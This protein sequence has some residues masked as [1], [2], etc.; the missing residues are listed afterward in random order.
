[1]Q[2]LP[3]LL[4]GVVSNWAVVFPRSLVRWEVLRHKQKTNQ[5]FAGGSTVFETNEVPYVRL[6]EELYTLLQ[7]VTP[8]EIVWYVGKQ[9][10]DLEPDIV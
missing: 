2:N 10:R 8:R 4:C 3:V 7:N 6:I 1:M 5:L 9:T